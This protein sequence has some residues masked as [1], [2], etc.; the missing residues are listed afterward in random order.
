MRSAAFRVSSWCRTGLI[1]ITLVCLGACVTSEND[2]LVLND[3]IAALSRRIENLEK[4]QASVDAQV[5]QEIESKLSPI[6]EGQA[7]T[8]NEIDELRVVV[9][10]LTGRVEENNFLLKRAVERDTTEM[11][12][13]KA[14]L[15]DL[16]QRIQVLEGK[17]KVAAVPRPP[18][19]VPVRKPPEQPKKPPEP[20][21]SPEQQLYDTSLAQFKQGQYDRAISGFKEFMGK[22]PRSNLADNAQF[23][24]G[25]CHMSLKQYEQAIL[26]FQKVIKDYPRGNKV[27][28]A[29][30]RQ[31]MAFNEI[32]DKTSSILLLK[33][34]VK[35]YPNSSE[36]KTARAK[37]KTLE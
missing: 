36:A 3:Q 8:V 24:L 5:T 4:S 37:L 35:N 33:K 34:I 2:I 27:P 25:E 16:S 19:V 29:L 31:A 1:F 11:D 10:S 26:A 12:L 14:S 30:L 13:L 21:V 22:Y 6:R 20:T 17:G 28:S 18:V 23:W 7:E 32:Q 9:Q 15:T